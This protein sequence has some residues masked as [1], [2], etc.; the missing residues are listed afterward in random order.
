MLHPAEWS[1]S[2]EDQA[3]KLIRKVRDDYSVQL[4]PIHVQHLD[5]FNQTQFRRVLSLD[6]D[7]TVMK[8]MDELFLLPSAPVAMPRA[9]WLDDTLSS[10]LMLVEP[11]L[12]E[13]R[14]ILNAFEQRQST[15]FD[16]EI[17]NELYG[18][19]C[20]TIPHR[21]YDLLTGEFRA[22]EH[23]R[24]LGSKEEKWDPEQVLNETKFVH[25]SDWPLPKPWLPHSEEQELDFRPE[26]RQTEEGEDCRDRDVWLGLYSDFAE[27]REPWLMFIGCR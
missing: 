25:F 10:Q 1:A 27:R 22:T 23:H 6:S 14:R 26:C 4:A 21:K 18:N 11:S 5:A 13:F 12:F 9:Y 19:D 3:A 8:S 7:A 24:Y 17:V 16:M 20:I 15:D 2:A